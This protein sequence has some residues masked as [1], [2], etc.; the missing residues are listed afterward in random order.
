MP[1]KGFRHSEETKEKNRIT[2]LGNTSRR[3]KK[4]SE[5]TKEKNRVV[6]LGNT[7]KRGKKCSPE[8]KEKCRLGSLG[9]SVGP[10]SGRWKGGKTEARKRA[11]L[12][13]RCRGFIPLN[14]Y[15][16]DS[17]NHHID[18][19]HI[20]YLPKELH[21]PKFIIHS[22]YT[23]K[24]MDEQNKVAFNYLFEHPE[25]MCMNREAVEN[26]YLIYCID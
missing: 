1:F 12:K 25:G 17:R 20:I 21:D 19:D 13:N 18:R 2:S 15:F 9:K 10:K 3:G 8:T 11:S 23:W 26:L 14:E 16:K 4:S 6:A 7:H 22:Y 5:E 24:G